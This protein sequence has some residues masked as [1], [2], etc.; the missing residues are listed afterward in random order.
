MT[1]RWGRRFSSFNKNSYS[2][3]RQR[4]KPLAT[5]RTPQTYSSMLVVGDRR[6]LSDRGDPPR[7]HQRHRRTHGRRDVGPRV[8]ASPTPSERDRCQATACDPA[9][10]PGRSWLMQ[11]CTRRRCAPTPAAWLFLNHR[12]FG[13]RGVGAQR[14]GLIRCSCGGLN[15][16]L[17]RPPRLANVQA[18]GGADRTLAAVRP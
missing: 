12:R 3:R 15:E 9:R 14:G 8:A 1:H 13:A 18:P 10:R 16:T 6:T 5:A 2:K 17:Q 4:T 7:R 11:R